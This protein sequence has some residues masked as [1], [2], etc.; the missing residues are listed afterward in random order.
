MDDSKVEIAEDYTKRK[1]VFRLKT[2]SGSECLFQVW[3]TKNQVSPS[4]CYVWYYEIALTIIVWYCLFCYPLKAESDATLNHWVSAIED[5]LHH[6]LQPPHSNT[7]NQ[8][9]STQYHFSHFP[10]GSATASPNA[11]SNRTV[12]KDDN[13]T[14]HSA[15]NDEVE[16]IHK[17]NSSAPASG[18]IDRKLT[19]GSRNRSPTG[20]SPKEK[21]RKASAGKI[22][23]IYYNPLCWILIFEFI[24]ILYNSSFYILI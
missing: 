11:F 5:T 2:S 22:F 7:S 16:D 15:L 21:S 17:K 19:I 13:E 18:K 1:C 23:S 4:K 20:S 3:N 8:K 10:I 12:E 24:D 14:N 6:H 9:S